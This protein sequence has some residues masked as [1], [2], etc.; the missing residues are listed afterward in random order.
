MPWPPLRALLKVGLWA[1]NREDVEAP[2]PRKVWVFFRL[3]KN[4]TRGPLKPTQKQLSTDLA[5]TLLASFSGNPPFDISAIEALILQLIPQGHM[6]HQASMSSKGHV[7]T[8]ARKPWALM[9]SAPLVGYAA[10]R[11]ATHV[12]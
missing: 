12:V 11:Y 3:T 6:T 7:W 10:R 1:N 4:W 2:H 5:R 9:G 8:S